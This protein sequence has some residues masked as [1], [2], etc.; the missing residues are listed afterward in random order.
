[1]N[2][3]KKIYL[4]FILISLLGLV[5]YLGYLYGV[6]EKTNEI[7]SK[8]EVVSQNQNQK[9]SISEIQQR[10][11]LGIDPNSFN[12]QTN[13]YNTKVYGRLYFVINDNNQTEISIQMENIPTQLSINKTKSV[14]VPD[15]LSID[16]A[17]REIDPADNLDTYI[18]QNISP[19]PDK[20]LAT[21]ALDETKDGLR[22]A[23][24]SGFINKSILDENNG[25]TN[26]ERI[27]FR[28]IDL[29]VQNIFEDRN[30]D[31]PVKIRGNSETNPA[32]PA[33]PAPF[34]W[35]LI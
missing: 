12:N 14:I 8:T 5:Y 24:F 21:I 17:I 4:I 28:S 1:M 29:S 30:K 20:N 33:E 15:K 2:L 32:I 3:V 26:I 7:L 25:R 18:Y 16:L 10:E 22:S 23:K 34:F 13:S 35:V 31:L 6:R 19:K 27:V 9:N 11:I